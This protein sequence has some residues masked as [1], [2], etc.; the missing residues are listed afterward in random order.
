[1]VRFPENVSLSPDD[2]YKIAKILAIELTLAKQIEL[3]KL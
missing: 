1:M 3:K 2:F